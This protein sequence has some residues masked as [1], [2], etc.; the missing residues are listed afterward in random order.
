ME[1]PK[2]PFR[3]KNRVQSFRYGFQGIFYA[4]KTQPNV[5]IHFLV[6][7]I[8]IIAGICLQITS[9]EWLFVLACIG[10]VI[11]LELFNSALENLCDTL[12]PEQSNQIK[13]VKD[14]AAGAVLIGAIVAAIIGMLIF[15]PKFVS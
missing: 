6:T 8:V 9:V 10:I 7:T 4:V 15:V 13:H 12:H 2:E 3:I 14:M 1:H 5:R 11:G